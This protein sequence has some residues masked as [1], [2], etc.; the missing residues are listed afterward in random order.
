MPPNH[1]INL[2]LPPEISSP[3]PL[4]AQLLPPLSLSPPRLPPSHSSS[5][6]LA[7]LSLACGG[8]RRGGGRSLSPPLLACARADAGERGAEA[9]CVWG[10]LCF[11]RSGTRPSFCLSPVRRC[12]RGSSLD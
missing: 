9:R 6:R 8:I 1:L 12:H 11:S 7:S 10:F 3:L 2:A 5:P 4:S